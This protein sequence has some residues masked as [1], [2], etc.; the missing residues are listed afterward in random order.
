MTTNPSVYWIIQDE[1]TE[2]FLRDFCT[3]SF[4]SEWTN[5]ER[6]ALYISS[7]QNAKNIASTLIVQGRKHLRVYGI[8]LKALF[9]SN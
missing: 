3:V 4:K 8:N 6:E 1:D 5:N 7:F 9:N 2:Q